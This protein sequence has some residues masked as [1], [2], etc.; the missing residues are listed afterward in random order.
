MNGS[1]DRDKENKAVEILLEEAK[2]D[3]KKEMAMLEDFKKF[4][5]KVKAD[6]AK[7]PE[8]EKFNIAKEKLQTMNWKQAFIRP[9]ENRLSRWKNKS[10]FFN[11]M[12]K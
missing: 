6:K 11:E 1:I 2:Q 5:E 8:E 3:L 4:T 10:D 12:E 7:I 9:Y